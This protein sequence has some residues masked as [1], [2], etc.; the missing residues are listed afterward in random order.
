MSSRHRYEH[1]SQIPQVIYNMSFIPELNNYYFPIM[2][3]QLGSENSTL[4][5]V[6]I[7]IHGGSFQVGAADDHGPNYIMDFG[8]KS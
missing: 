8:K 5:P 4:K 1:E 7:Y 6:A 2:T 3:L